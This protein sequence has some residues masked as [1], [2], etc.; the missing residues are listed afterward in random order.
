VTF[1]NA[2]IENVDYGLSESGNGTATYKGSFL[3]VTDMAI[4]SCDWGQVNGCGVDATYTDWGSSSGPGSLVCGVVITNPWT[5]NG[6]TYTGG[7][8]F[9]DG[10]CDDVQTPDQVLGSS[11][12]ESEAY[13][14]D[15]QSLC[16]E[17]P[18][19]QDACQAFNDYFVCTKGAV[20]TAK[21]GSALA[22]DLLPDA[23]DLSDMD[24]FD[25]TL[26]QNSTSDLLNLVED[27]ADAS[28]I[29]QTAGGIIN[30]FTT[31]SSSF[32]SCISSAPQ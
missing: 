32:D 30:L 23:G 2:K 7:S 12:S 8:I 13:A 19:Q 14:E 22:T 26:S 25:S 1:D 24:D 28:G 27:G 15:E 5:Y 31:M 17:Q 3:N 11:I 6:K 4:Q 16:D 21:E 10:N 29:G 18:S 9:G 20:N